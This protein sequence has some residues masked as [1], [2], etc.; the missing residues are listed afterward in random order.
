MDQWSKVH[1]WVG[2]N[3]ESEEQFNKYFELDYS[4]P[5]MDIDDP[6]Y[7]V[8]Q[9]CEDINKRWYDEDFF[10]V[11]IPEEYPQ[12]VDV[13][14]LLE[15]LNVSEETLT[16]IKNICISKGFEKANTIFYY[17]DPEITVKDKGKLYNGLVYIGKFDT[18]Y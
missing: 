16:K 7:K 1:V 14:K 2:I 5:D 3:N 4:D 11:F 8:C 18:D 17:H 6:S 10:G 9:F 15:E 12:L 13:D